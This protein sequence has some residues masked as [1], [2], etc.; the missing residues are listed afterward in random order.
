[1]ARAFE[2]HGLAVAHAAGDRGTLLFGN[3]I[4]AHRTLDGKQRQAAAPHLLSALTLALETRDEFSLARSLEGVAELVAP[5]EPREAAQLAGAAAALRDR[6]GA[7]PTP[8]DRVRLDGW[9]AGARLGLGQ[10]GFASA[11]AAGRQDAL[12]HAI[13]R[14]VDLARA[15]GDDHC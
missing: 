6:H 3:L 1:M 11:W 14:A 9:S 12:E 8:L 7:S 10:A 5:S 13:A 4:A 15:A 2:E